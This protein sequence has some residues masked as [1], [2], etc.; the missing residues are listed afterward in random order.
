[1]VNYDLRGQIE[2]VEEMSSD[3]EAVNSFA[4]VVGSDRYGRLIYD[5]GVG[6]RSKEYA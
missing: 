4:V 3:S 6:G 1:M 5:G 2:P